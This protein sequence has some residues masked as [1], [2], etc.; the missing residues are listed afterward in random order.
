MALDL[1]GTFLNS[2]KEVTKR[3][4]DAV[5]KCT[6]VGIK[7]IIA[8]ARP[9]RSV[10][11][12]IPSEL[13][14]HCSF[15]FYN[16]A[17]IVD[18]DHNYEEHVFIPQIL[19]AEIVDYCLSNIPECHLSIEVK[20]T[21]YSNKGISEV[22]AAFFNIDTKPVVISIE[23]LKQLEATKILLTGYKQ[24][25][26]LKRHFGKKVNIIVT[27]EGALVQIM[28]KKVSKASGIANLCSRYSIDLSDV[29]VFGDDTNDID[30][31][32]TCGHRV[33]MMNAIDE[34]KEISD[35]VTASNDQDGVGVVLERVVD[36]KNKI[37]Y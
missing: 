31:F 10:K 26:E 15:V 13:M 7:I 33:A 3:N 2:K 23:E 20:D 16:G 30:M 19:S 5:L 37:Y 8:T 29:M 4:M 34:L 22:N 21:W 9:P 35:E 24:I 18:Y 27:D 11:E 17:Y 28:Y 6:E 1:D 25:E 32:K 12:F 36:L 14:K